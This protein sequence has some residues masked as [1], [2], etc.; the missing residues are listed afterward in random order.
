MM[1]DYFAILVGTGVTIIVQSSSVT[2]S[3]LT[4]LCGMG[5]LK[6]EKML[7]LSLGANI[8]TTV[9]A[10]IAGLAELK[11]DALQIAFVHFLFNVIG[12]CIWF[13]FPPMRA[14]PL[15]ASRTLGMY[16]AH[17]RATPAVY[18]L[19]VFVALPGLGLALSAVFDASVV[20]GVF[21]LFF[22]LAALGWFVYWWVRMEGCYRVLSKEDR[23]RVNE[24]LAKAEADL[25]GFVNQTSPQK[26]DVDSVDVIASAI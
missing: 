3:A 7:P 10:L 8:G 9:T 1:N 25:L 19:T 26:E 13:P 23:D 17:L 21:V 24:Q 16:A 14:V 15:N 20:A 18:L 4:P 22:V 2:T 6:L 11:H 12:I 5:V